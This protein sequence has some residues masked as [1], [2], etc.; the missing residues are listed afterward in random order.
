MLSFMSVA[1][2]APSRAVATWRLSLLAAVYGI[3]AVAVMQPV[4]D[5][6][7]WWHLG[8]G[9]WIV[10]NG[11]VPTTDPLHA[12]GESRPWVAY[13]WL[14]EVV[15]FALHRAFGLHGVLLYR[16]LLTFAVLANLHR[17]LAK[18]ETRFL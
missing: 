1:P 15:L 12:T 7:L 8:V 6:D 18:R 10:D 16:G 13:S 3:A 14:F 11:G 9:G 2:A 5:D 4:L 17:F